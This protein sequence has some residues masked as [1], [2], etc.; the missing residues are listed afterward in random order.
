VSAVVDAERVQTSTHTDDAP[1]ATPAPRADATLA[2]TGRLAHKPH[3]A[4]EA[5]RQGGIHPVVVMEIA[6]VGPANQHL[7]SHV[8]CDT[9]EAAEALAA[10]LKRGDE[11]TVAG[12]LSNI[13]LFLGAATLI[14][15]TK[16][17]A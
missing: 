1:A 13:R 12:S 3:A 10:S 5:D 7:L 11:V 6:H 8:K 16:E 14:T 17:P 2:F 4:V 15:P 9:H